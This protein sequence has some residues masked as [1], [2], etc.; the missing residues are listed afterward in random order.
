MFESKAIQTNDAKVNI[1][2][3]DEIII[4]KNKV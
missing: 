4:G 2:N 1:D 3:N